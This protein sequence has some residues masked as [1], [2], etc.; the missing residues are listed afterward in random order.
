V[1]LDKLLDHITRHRLTEPGETIC[2][3][4]SGGPDSTALLTALFALKDNL[5]INL[6]VCHVN[7]GLRGAESDGDMYFVQKLAKSLSIPCVT[8]RVDVKKHQLAVG[9][10]VQSSARELRYLAFDRIL[11][12]KAADKIATAHTADDNA[13][14][15]L[16]NLVR[17]SGTAGL[18]GIPRQRNKT[19]I[20]PLLGLRKAELMAYLDANGTAHRIDVSNESDKYARNRI[21]HNLVPLLEKDF[22]PAIVESLCKTAEIMSETR[23]FIE[24]QAGVIF[25]DVA[26]KTG[27][28]GFSI[29]RAYMAPLHPALQREIIR[30]ALTVLGR[31]LADISF[32]HTENIR[33]LAL[34]SRDGEETLL[35]RVRISVAHGVVYFLRSPSA[36][37]AE[38]SH[39]FPKLGS[40]SLK[41]TGCT[42]TVDDVDAPPAEFDPAYNTVYLDADAVPKEAV[43]RNRRDGDIFQPIGAPGHMKLKKFLIGRQIPRWERDSLTLL[44]G[45]NEILWVA[46]SRI[47]ERVRIT[48]ATKR[49]LKISLHRDF[50]KL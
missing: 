39:P 26:K 12:K 15:V 7:H 5:K 36:R 33:R 50:V 47:S 24:Q 46:G 29:N 13:E 16:L 30:I 43:L 48:P 49:L 17:G 28:N 34:N 31:G 18:S 6:S 45:A 3:A 27:E 21:R 14:T 41:E 23:D 20:R 37:P 2:V 40:V 38:F 8:A 25:L 11:R 4:A 10:S 9:G 42:V 44:A 32:E 1:F 35:H 22:N 19:I